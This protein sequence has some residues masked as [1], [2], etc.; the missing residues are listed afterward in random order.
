MCIR[1]RHNG[2]VKA[3]VGGYSYISSEFNRATQAQRQ[4]GSAFK[5][6]VYAAALENGYL[7]NTLI[8]DAPFVIDDY[9]KDGIWRPTNYGDKFYGLSTLRLGVEKSRNLMT[10]RLSDR[11]GLD[12]I[13]KISTDLGIYEKFPYVISSSLGS[14]ESSLLKIT[15]AYAS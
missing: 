4:P 5:P 2:E 14:L 8:L 6:I 9:S 13:A 12:K 3:L 11:I 10:V 1:D 7:P 15:S